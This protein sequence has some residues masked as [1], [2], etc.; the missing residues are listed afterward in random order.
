MQRVVDFQNVLACVTQIP[1][2]QQEAYSAQAQIFLMVARNSVGNESDPCAVGLSAPGASFCTHAKL[3]SFVHLCVSVRLML[4]L[5]PSPT[6]KNARAIIE[7]LVD[8]D[9][10][11]IFGRGLQRVGGYVGRQSMSG[12]VIT[13]RHPISS[14]V[15]FI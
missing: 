2:P 8:V 7:R 12:Q 3:D 1:V 11:S 15:G 13:N 6:C 10:K 9:A 5:V 4:A 14:H